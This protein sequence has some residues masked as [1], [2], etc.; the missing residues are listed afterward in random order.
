MLGLRQRNRLAREA[1]VLDA[2]AELF[3]RQ[4]YET[5]RIEEVAD[6]AGVSAQTV[7]NYFANKPN[8]LIALAVRHVRTSIPERSAFVRDPP[9]DPVDAIKRFESLLADQALRTLTRESWCAILAASML[10]QRSRA[11]RMS[12]RFNGLIRRHYKIMLRPFQER[13]KIRRDIDIDALAELLTAIGTHNFTRLVA[14]DGMTLD[15]LKA[16][17][18]RQLAP[19]FVGV[20]PPEKDDAE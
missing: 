16:A 18:E 5:T 20:I 4:G 17:V 7:Y 9:E 2:A 14:E 15:E 1:L 10:D 12:L 13:G 8:I 11:R 6:L 3:R 19:V